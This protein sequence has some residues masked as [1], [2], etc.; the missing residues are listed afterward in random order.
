MQLL[1]SLLGM[2]LREESSGVGSLTVALKCVWSRDGQG[3]G[4][5]KRCGCGM[6][7]IGGWGQNRPFAVPFEYARSSQE[8]S[9]SCF[10]YCSIE[11]FFNH[12]TSALASEKEQ[13][14]I[15][16]SSCRTNVLSRSH[17]NDGT[18]EGQLHVCVAAERQRRR[19]EW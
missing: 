1:Q 16:D 14:R 17:S 5:L 15:T 7:Q 8:C 3:S 18:K 6:V 10:I 11:S 19:R 4:S 9:A 12:T 13:H 2:L